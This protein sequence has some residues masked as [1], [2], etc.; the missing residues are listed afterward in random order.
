[1]YRPRSS[2]GSH[3]RGILD[4]QGEGVR[5][6]DRRLRFEIGALARNFLAKDSL[7]L[8]SQKFYG[9]FYGHAKFHCK[10]A[11]FCA[12][13]CKYG[14]AEIPSVRNAG[15]HCENERK[16]LFLNYESPALTAELQAQ[17]VEVRISLRKSD[18]ERDDFLTFSD[19]FVMRNYENFEQ[20]PDQ[21]IL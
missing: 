15:R 5:Q 4:D 14:I 9:P 18:A 6:Q 20:L 11:Q 17:S 7:Y 19:D 3:S 1:R 21:T 12:T 16:R 13:R 8:S 2:R 10:T